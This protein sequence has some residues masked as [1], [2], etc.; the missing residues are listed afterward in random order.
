MLAL[1]Y[2]AYKHFR[3]FDFRFFEFSIGAILLFFTIL[4]V[5]SSLF[6]ASGG[7]VGSFAVDG[8]RRMIGSVGV[9]IFNITIFVLSLVLIFEDR[10]TDIIK[11]CFI[12]SRDESLQ[13]EIG[14]DFASDADAAQRGGLAKHSSAQ[15]LRG[16]ENFNALND[17]LSAEDNSAKQ[18]NFAEQGASERGFESGQNFQNLNDTREPENEQN[19]GDAQGPQA[20]AE[21][22]LKMPQKGKPSRLKRVERLSEVAENKRLLD[23]LDKGRVAK[24]KDFKLPPLDFLNL[25]PKKKS[26][27]DESEIDRKIY[28]LLDK[29]RKFKIDGD[30]VRTYSGPVVTTFEF[31]PAA[32]IKVSKILTLQDDL[33]MALR[34]QTIRIQAPVPGKDVVGIEIPNQNIDTIYLREILES[35]VFKSASSPL[36]IVLG[37]DIVGQPFV[38]DLK[39]LPHLLIAGTTGSGKSVGINAM[40]L[41]LLYRNSPKSLRLI[42]IDP[43]MLEFSIYNDIPHLLTPVITQPK[44][45]IIALS[46]L[47]AEMEQRYSLMAQNRTKNIDNYNEKMLREGGEILP[48]IVV[49]IDEL[50]DLMMTSGKDVEHYI[51][52]LAQMAR[53]SGIHLIVA[54]QRP[55]VDVVTGLIKANLPSRISFRV[56]SKVDS[57]VILDQMGADSLLGRGDM[58]FTPPTAPGLIRLHAPFTTENEINK[59]AEFLKAQESVVYDERFLIENEG[60]KQEGGIINPQNIVLDE[61][62]DEAK[63]IV[64]EEEK[65]SISYLQRR[66]RIG[67]NRAATIIEQLE[68]MGVLS[69]INAKGQRDIIK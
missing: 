50:A 65:T 18:G 38:T 49:I 10:F 39:K 11:N 45:A 68:Q 51:A 40:L 22:E 61:L 20:S 16:A 21:R 4:M 46:N 1:A 14:D 29:L 53:A 19:F 60:A 52:R 23:Q 3:G 17:T 63:A 62:Y 12:G 5:Q 24:P 27:I 48:Y 57:K 26:S 7:A 69:E 31:R 9:W 43:K 67:Y 2:V 55:S 6:G 37:K 28:D 32:H 41:S 66:L 59:I 33:A 34:A 47:V 36:T 54:T 58:L 25:P 8:L 35:D 64:L 44:Q 56:G 13:D 30:V 15:G 42:M